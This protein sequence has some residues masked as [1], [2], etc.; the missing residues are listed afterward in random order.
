M[1]DLFTLKII[2]SF[3]VGAAY[4][5]VA[6]IAA[7]KL[8]SKVGG[9]ISGLPST[10][11][12][13]LLFIGWTQNAEASVEATLLIP[14]VIGVACLFAI[15][16]IYLIKRGLWVALAAALLVWFVAAYALVALDITDFFI[17]LIIFV[18]L[19]LVCHF[20]V[21]NVLHVP[22]TKA[23]KIVYSP[24]IFLLRGLIS[25]SVVALSVI[26]A[27]TGGP[28]IGGIF[29]AFPAMLSGTLLITYYAHGAAFSA[30]QPGHAL[31]YR[32]SWRLL[33]RQMAGQLQHQSQSMRRWLPG[34]QAGKR[35]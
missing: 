14:A 34:P 9:L 35:R 12:F 28:V 27:K 2:L 24:Q 25:G 15:T 29:T 26:L 17:S 3:I 11:L 32:R 19:F 7:D 30:S 4:T 16:Y 31:L 21:V 8:G 6:T 20:V 13:G 23:N 18:V 10:V 1:V 22:A 5:L 33:P